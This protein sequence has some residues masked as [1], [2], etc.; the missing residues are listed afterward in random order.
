MNN[1]NWLQDACGHAVEMAGY[2]PETDK[3]AWICQLC[4][5]TRPINIAELLGSINSLKEKK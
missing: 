1:K 5:R 3:N 2:D 4:G